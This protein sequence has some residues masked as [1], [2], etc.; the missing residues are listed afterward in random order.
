MQK[1]EPNTLLCGPAFRSYI[2]IPDEYSNGSSNGMTNNRCFG[3]SYS[4][5]NDMGNIMSNGISCN[6]LYLV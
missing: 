2:I 4:I 5:S 1:M 3:M 6:K